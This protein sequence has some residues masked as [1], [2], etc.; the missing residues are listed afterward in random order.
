MASLTNK[1]RKIRNRKK[2]RAGTERKRKLR[3]QGSTP[4]FAIHQDKDSAAAKS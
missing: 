3:T 2:S 4:K 1:T